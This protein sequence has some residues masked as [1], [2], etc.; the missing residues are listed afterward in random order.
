VELL[1]IASDLLFPVFLLIA[2]GLVLWATVAAVR[3]IRRGE[4][5]WQALKTWFI[6]IID[7]VSGIG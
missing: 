1:E 4:S 2:V 7:A 3:S 6:R 5:P